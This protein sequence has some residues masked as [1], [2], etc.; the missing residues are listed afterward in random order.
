[1]DAVERRL[2]GLTE[3]QKPKPVQQPRPPRKKRDIFD[4]W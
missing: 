3:P 4:D 1:M 2:K